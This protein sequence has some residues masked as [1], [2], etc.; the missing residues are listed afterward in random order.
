MEVQEM[1]KALADVVDTVPRKNDDVIALYNEKFSHN[2][3]DEINS[4][5]IPRETVEKTDLRIV[6]SDNEYTYIGA[7]DTPPHMINFMGMQKFTRGQ[8]TTVTNPTVL[9]KIKNH[10]CFVKGQVD[11]EVLFENDEKAKKEAEH[12]REE[13]L[14]LQI[15]VERQNRAA[16]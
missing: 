4:D 13:D 14:K 16:S 2:D 10:T 5:D 7:G 1:R 6:P 9:A 8:V 3:A 15:L 12:Q 11:Q